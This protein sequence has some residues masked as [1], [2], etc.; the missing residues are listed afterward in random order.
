MR[1]GRPFPGREVHFV[2]LLS[3]RVELLISIKVLCGELQGKCMM[4]ETMEESE[5]RIENIK[6]EIRES[7]D[8]VKHMVAE[9]E[10]FVRD[11]RQLPPEAPAR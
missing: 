11:H 3:K 10:I 6:A 1:R 5:V 2:A 8:R 9:S 4:S 7:I